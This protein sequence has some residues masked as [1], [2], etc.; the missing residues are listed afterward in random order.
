MELQQAFHPYSS[1]R[2]ILYGERGEGSDSLEKALKT[3][4]KK[5]FFDMQHFIKI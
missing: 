2:E 4:V 1:S 5:V 3:S